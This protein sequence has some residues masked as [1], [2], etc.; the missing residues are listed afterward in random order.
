MDFEN[1]TLELTLLEQHQAARD[2]DFIKRICQAMVVVSGTF[3]AAAA[4]GAE[5]PVKAITFGRAFGMNQEAYAKKAASYM[6]TQLPIADVT[7]LNDQQLIALV[8]R[9]WPVFAFAFGKNEQL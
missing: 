6:A 8:G 4:Q 3:F 1:V 2:S 5:I 9:Y 7:Q